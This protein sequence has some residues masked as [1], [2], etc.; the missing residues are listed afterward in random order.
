MQCSV[1]QYI[2]LWE[3]GSRAD[4]SLSTR[5]MGRDSLCAERIQGPG[6][7][8]QLTQDVAEG[9]NAVLALAFVQSRAEAQRNGSERD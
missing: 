9:G 5:L 8:R 7:R 1:I 2:R 3:V 4:W 6:G